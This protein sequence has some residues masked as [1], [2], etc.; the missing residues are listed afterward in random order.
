MELANRFG[1]ATQ[2]WGRVAWHQGEVSFGAAPASGGGD[3]AR[4]TWAV[5]SVRDHLAAYAF[6]PDVLL[7][8]CVR[9]PVPTEDDRERWVD[10]GWNPERQARLLAVLGDRVKPIEWNALQREQWRSNYHAA[11]QS[12]SETRPDAFHLTRI[13][14]IDSLPRTV[15]GIDTVCGYQDL[16]ELRDDGQV[17]RLDRPDTAPGLVAASVAWDF[18]VPAQAQKAAPHL[19]AELEV[20]AAAVAVSGR[21]EYRRN[22]RAY[23][24]WVREFSDGTVTGPEAVA[25]AVDELHD[26]VEEQHE[27]VRDEWIDRAVRTGFLLGT[28]TLGMLAAP[29]APVVLAGAAVSVGEFTWTELRNRRQAGG[30]AEAKVAA[31]FCQIDRK[32][33]RK[34]FN[35][36]DNAF[37]S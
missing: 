22:R 25:D 16:D 36:S 26:L 27:L 9:V 30:D 6:V 19:D 32:V 2:A 17:V 13:Q 4:E 35:D 3:M 15:T 7:Y 23:W 11:Q 14:L 10:Q 8:D 34:F 28:V 21:K 29:L 37:G 1:S 5:Y 12:A 31:M 18:A 24:R 20:L 33:L